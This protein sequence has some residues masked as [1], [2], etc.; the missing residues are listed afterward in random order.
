MSI[1]D[2]IGRALIIAPHP[3]DEVLGCGGTLARLADHGAQTHV[4]V[5]TRGQSPRFDAAQVAAVRLEAAAAHAILGITQCHFL[6]LPAAELDRMAHADLNDKVA[7]LVERIAPD[8]LFLPFVGD[9]HV[10][11]QLVFTAGLVAARPRSKQFP[12]R[13]YAYETVS[14]TNWAAPGLTPTFAPNVHVDITAGLERKLAAFASFR[15]QVQAFPHER[16]VEALRALARVRGST[17]HAE[18]AEAF[19]LIR[20]TG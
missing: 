19:V 1:I 10:D 7:A 17:V 13:I 18:A 11:H 9:L 5:V 3:D 15:S 8:T 4:A 2:R 20:E 14:E 16:S 12:A 6:D